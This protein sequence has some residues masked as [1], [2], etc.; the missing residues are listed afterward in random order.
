LN[1][2]IGGGVIQDNDDMTLP[3]ILARP[4]EVVVIDGKPDGRFR[5]PGSEWKRRRYSMQ[6]QGV[7]MDSSL[8]PSTG[9]AAS[10]KFNLTIDR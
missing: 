10:M 6:I 1:I 5:V 8:T 3:L 9:P 7:Q 4:I 2:R